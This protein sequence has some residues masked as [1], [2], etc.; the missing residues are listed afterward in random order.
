MNCDLCDKPATV[1]ELTVKDGVKTEV[2]LCEDHAQSAG[3][4]AGAGA[5]SGDVTQFVVYKE[6]RPSR[7][8]SRTCRTCGTSFASFRRSG[9]LGC[10]DCY[11]AFEEQLAPMIE[12]AQNGGTSHAGK[13]P[14]RGGASIDR[15]HRIQALFRE[16]EDAVAAEQY[17]R[18]AELRDCLRD[19]E[20]ETGAAP[21]D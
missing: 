18:A 2:H 3:L 20:P 15:R 9:L 10:P 17:E 16:L 19:L 4:G 5:T 14:S 11:E 21:D 6:R 1:H 13:C 7:A 8:A 12:R